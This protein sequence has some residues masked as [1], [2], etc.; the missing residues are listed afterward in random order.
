MRVEGGALRTA[1]QMLRVDS[2]YFLIENKRQSL[3]LKASREG[4]R[5]ENSL[6]TEKRC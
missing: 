2:M 6:K 1:G 4:L 3:E 5:V